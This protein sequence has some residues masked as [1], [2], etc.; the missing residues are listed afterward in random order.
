MVKPAVTVDAIVIE[1]APLVILIP[2]PGVNVVLVNPVPLPISKAPLT[3]VDV[4]PVPPEAT[5]NADDNVVTPALEIL[6]PVV[7]PLLPTFKAI[8][9]V[10]PTPEVD[11]SVSVDEAVVPP[12]CS[13]AVI[14]VTNV[15][16]VA[17]ATTV[18]EPVV[19]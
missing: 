10:V 1:P 16:L 13:G 14:D 12:K 17:K 4:N 18:P 8:E 9:S 6:K 11:C 19:V 7:A 5:G 15:G 2:V 3:G